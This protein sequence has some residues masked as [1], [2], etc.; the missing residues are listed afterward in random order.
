[1]ATV[2]LTDA[3]IRKIITD[4]AGGTRAELTDATTTGLK[5]RA[6]KDGRAVWSIKL[7][8][9]AGNQIRI[10]LGEYPA[11]GISDARQACSIAR[12]QVRHE[13]KNPN[14]EKSAAREAAMAPAVPTDA[15]LSLSA[16]I[17]LYDKQVWTPNAL[18]SRAEAINRIRSVFGKF[19]DR[20]LKS[21][22]RAELQIAVDDWPAKSSS[23]GAVRY[24]RPVLKWAGKRDYVAAE[25]ALLEEPRWLKKRSRFLSEDELHK[26]LPVLKAST[27]PHAAVM[28]LLLLTATRLEQ[29][30][31]ARWHEFRTVEGQMIWTIP[32]ERVKRTKPTQAPRPHIIPLSRQA[33]ALIE[34]RGTERSQPDDLIFQTSSSL[35]LGNWDKEAKVIQKAAG[36]HDW[37]RHD[38][39]RTAAT[40]M[41]ALGIAPHVIEAALGHAEIHSALAGIYNQSRYSDEV[42]E[43]LQKLADWL[44]EICPCQTGR[45]SAER[46]RGS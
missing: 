19:L 13:G 7:R 1:M 45:A 27:R 20:S 33:A 15:G 44:D 24:V 28:R 26:L 14:V 22:T 41:G 17:D 36:V 10:N 38:L 6:T 32:P 3:S 23:A 12:H 16:L 39:R 43:A 18:K 21:I 29:A 46:F 31:Q 30:A 8:D 35:A 37:H 4:A 34:G 11:V 2:R 25:L 9:Q 42:R 5:I 40:S